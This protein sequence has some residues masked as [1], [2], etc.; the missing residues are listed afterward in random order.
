MSLTYFN[1]GDI[2]KTADATSGGF[3]SMYFVDVRDVVSLANPTPDTGKIAKIVLDAGKQFYAAL[4][5][6]NRRSFLETPQNGDGGP[7]FKMVIE[8]FLP[9]AQAG[10][11]TILNAMKHGRYIVFVELHGGLVK[12]VGNLARGANFEHGFS[13][14]SGYT[15]I[16]GTTIRFLWEH[17]H[18]APLFD[19]SGYVGPNNTGDAGGGGPVF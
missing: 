18:N 9:F 6:I 14:E 17:E 5:I 13:T 19:E 3:A 2:K 16:P 8:G 4:P 11:E 7:Y 1:I 15:D 10:I 12:V